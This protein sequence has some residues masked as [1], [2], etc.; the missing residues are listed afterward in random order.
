[1]QDG[2]AIQKRGIAVFRKLF[3]EKA[4]F[5]WGSIVRCGR[6]SLC[7][8]F[9]IERDGKVILGWSCLDDIWSSSSP[10]LRF[11]S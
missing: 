5:L 3:A 2:L 7:V 6:Q 1:L 8:P 11:A 4:V 10:A 9:L